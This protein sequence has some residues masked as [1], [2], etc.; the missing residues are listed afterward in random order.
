MNN[1]EIIN[2]NNFYKNIRKNLKSDKKYYFIY[3]N[4]KIKNSYK[5]NNYEEISDKIHCIHALNI[6]DLK[7]RYNYIYDVVCDYLDSE[8][9]QNNIC[10]FIND[11]CISVRN[12]GHCPE[13]LHGCCYGRN[14]KLC[15]HNINNKCGIK[16]ISC[17]LFTCKYL[18][19]KGIK[20]NINSIP[21]LKI[22]FNYKQKE[23]LEYSLF[24]DKEE[25][26]QLLLKYK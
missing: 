19:K 23:I 7:K 5:L 20:F 2:D 22:F 6:K 25:V 12:N 9:N 8:F 3:K 21:L 1:Y 18:R 13:S 17:K 10:D 26:I 15:K 14:R 4:A 11:R 24:T 16:S